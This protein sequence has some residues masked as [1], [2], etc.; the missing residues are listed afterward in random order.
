MPLAALPPKKARFDPKEDDIAPQPGPQMMFLTTSADI[1]GYGGAAGGGKSFGLLLESLRHIDN[2]GFNWVIF[3]RTYPMITAKGGLWDES[4]QIFPLVEG[5]A[6]QTT[7]EWDFPSGASGKFAHMQYEKDKYDWQGAQI[8]LICCEENTPVLMGD[9]TQKAVCDLRAGDVVMTVEGPRPIV[10]KGARREEECVEATVYDADR[11]AIG[12]QVH[13]DSHRVL[14]PQGWLSYAD[15][16]CASRPSSS[17]SPTERPCDHKCAEP[18]ET[19]CDTVS[20]SPGIPFAG[21]QQPPVSIPISRDHQFGSDSYACEGQQAQGNGCARSACEHGAMQRRPLVNVPVVLYVPTPQLSVRDFRQHVPEHESPY[22]HSVSQLG[23]CQGDYSG[24]SR[25]YDG[26]PHHVRG[27]VQSSPQRLSDVAGHSPIDCSL[28]ELQETHRYSRPPQQYIHP[29]RKDVRRA[30]VDLQYGSCDLTPCGK[31]WVIDLT[32]AEVSHYCT[33]SGLVNQNCFDELT[34]FLRSQV[35]Y[36]FSRNRSTCGV[37]PYMRFTF[38]PDADSWVKIFFAPWVSEDWPE[39]DRA[40]SG[41]IRYFIIEN[42]EQVWLPKDGTYPNEEYP[43][44]KSI[45]FIEADIHD[46]P[47]LLEKDPGYLANLHAL[48]LVERERLLNKNWKIRAEGGNKFKKHWFPILEYIPD[49]I[50]KIMRFWDFA[51]T[52]E[53]PANSQR[54]GPDYTASVKAGR[55]R[56]G[57]YPR[58]VILDATWDRK[59]PGKVEELVKNTAMQDG[60]ECEVFFEEEG[61]ASGKTNTFNYKTKVLEGFVSHGIRSTG[62]KELRAHIASSQAEAGNI[63]IL[64]ACWNDGYFGFLEPFPSAKVHDDPVD[65]TSGVMQQL[66]LPGPVGGAIVGVVPLGEEDMSPDTID[67]HPLNEV[68]EKYKAFF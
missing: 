37:K 43:F 17:S 34:H 4:S 33:I 6:K 25:P 52:E 29:Y 9:G 46:N 31:H 5:V 67:G 22:V 28:D 14:T 55:R 1:A 2:S 56:A 12:R 49:D 50:E 59:S 38:N 32:I 16:A 19:K 63:G 11:R 13:S 65:A 20:Q 48:P 23:D 45:T 35:L 3:R 62:S 54:D 68:E 27:N 7:L 58:Y 39:E 53:I 51:A 66:F 10:W 36:M 60:R 24:D 57:A 8:C 26:Q 15:I 42:D 64:K 21:Q 47:K 44:A 61:G 30:S 40:Q 18:S 41:E